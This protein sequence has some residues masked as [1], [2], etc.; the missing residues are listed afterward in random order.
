M[1]AGR[2]G[3]FAA[4]TEGVVTGR[5][6]WWNPEDWPIPPI[7]VNLRRRD[8]PDPDAR[9]LPGRG[10]P[11]RGPPR[12]LRGSEARPHPRHLRRELRERAPGDAL[13]APVPEYARVPRRRGGDGEPAPG[14]GA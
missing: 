11:A 1:T 8:R 14:D 4:N 7:L 6:S 5:S 10:L 13:R 2:S 9:R 12:R 3:A